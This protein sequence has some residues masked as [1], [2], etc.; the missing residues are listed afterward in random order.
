MDFKLREGERAHNR[1][2]GVVAAV[3][4]DHSGKSAVDRIRDEEC[5]G[6]V[7]IG[8][9]EAIDIAPV[10]CGFLR[11]QNLHNIEFLLG[12]RRELLLCQGRKAPEGKN[13]NKKSRKEA[14]VKGHRSPRGMAPM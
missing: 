4:V 5:V 14:E 11:Q 3:G 9:R 12:N 1:L 7:F 8:L 2:V 13:K 6:R 10:P